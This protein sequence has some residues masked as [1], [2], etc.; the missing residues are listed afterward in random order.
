[1]MICIWGGGISCKAATW[2]NKKW[3]DEIKMNFKETGCE[4]VR[5]SELF[6]VAALMLAVL[7]LF[8]LYQTVSLMFFNRSAVAFWIQMRF[9][10]CKQFFTRCCNSTPVSFPSCCPKFK[11]CRT[12]GHSVRMCHYTYICF[13]CYS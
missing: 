7:L 2:M 5:G 9:Y 12:R 1:M 11:R 4:D 8:L 13:M 3:K 6:P 10:T